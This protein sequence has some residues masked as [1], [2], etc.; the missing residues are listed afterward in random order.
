MWK[1]NNT[2]TVQLAR[3]YKLG[4]ARVRE[5]DALCITCWFATQPPG[6]A[7]VTWLTTCAPFD[8]SIW[9]T[10]GLDRATLQRESD[11]GCMTDIGLSRPSVP[12]N[13]SVVRSFVTASMT[14]RTTAI[15]C[16]DCISGCSRRLDTKRTL[17]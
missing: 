6:T 14:V 1:F 15:F 10:F 16:L 8:S 13:S 9:S 17:P 11:S 7:L 2:G 3:L 12:L 4:W 5:L